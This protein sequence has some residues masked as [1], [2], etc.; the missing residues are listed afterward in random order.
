MEEDDVC[1]QC[2]LRV[3]PHDPE[4]LKWGSITFHRNCIKKMQERAH[5]RNENCTLVWRG[6][7]SRIVFVPRQH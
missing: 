1:P 3:A 7:E 6:T 4:R 5:L 2:H